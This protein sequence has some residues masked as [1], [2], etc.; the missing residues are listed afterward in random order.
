MLVL[1][2]IYVLDRCLIS[3]QVGLINITLLLNYLLFLLLVL[4]YLDL[5]LVVILFCC[6][7]V[8]CGYETFNA[9]EDVDAEDGD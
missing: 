9:K 6:H 7:L 8:R 1:V 3:L 4:A 5:K 2:V